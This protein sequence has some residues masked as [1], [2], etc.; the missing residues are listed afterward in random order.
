MNGYMH[1]LTIDPGRAHRYSPHHHGLGIY[2]D[3]GMSGHGGAGPEGKQPPTP[4]SATTLVP[5]GGAGGGD[6][7]HAHH[8][9]PPTPWAQLASHAPANEFSQE[10]GKSRSHKVT[11]VELTST[12]S[13]NNGYFAP[14]PE[15][16]C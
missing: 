14:A 8:P 11:P 12:A 9:L 2:G 5:G 10:G 13:T 7:D 4:S 6:D 1:N 16:A 3:S 15:Q